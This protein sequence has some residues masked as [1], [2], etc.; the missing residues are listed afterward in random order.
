[1]V[2]T[3]G[4]IANRRKQGIDTILMRLISWLGSKGVTALVWD[5][6]QGLVPEATLRPLEDIAAGSDLVVALGGDGTLLRAARVVG[7][8]LTPVVGVNVGSLGFLTEVTIEEMDQALD[9]IL[10]GEYASEDRMNL[11]ALVVR[12]Q[13][14]VERFTALNDLVINKGAL[15]RV[16]EMK[17]TVDGHY[18]ADYTADGLVVS[19][20]TGST[21]YSLSAGGPIVNPKMDAIIATP[22]C[23]HTLGVRPMLLSAEQVLVVE[24]WAGHGVNGE[25]EVKL[26]VDGQVGFDLLSGDIVS[27]KRSQQR[28][29][30]V[31]SRER[32]FYEVLRQKL[33][34]GDTRRKS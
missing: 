6:L 29:R 34:W 15:A 5:D 2:K 3:C 8:R 7:S 18:V 31:L 17:M 26:T 9:A 23:P 12:G 27:F 28:T 14:E 13:R 21:A 20:P 1:M 32:S 33:R 16:I 22:I 11:D 10:K 25:P 24:L 30:L 4:V 19:T